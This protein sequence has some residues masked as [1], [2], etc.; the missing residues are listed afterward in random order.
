[1]L[2]SKSRVVAVLVGGGVYERVSSTSKTA[3][4]RSSWGALESKGSVLRNYGR[5]ESACA[6][7]AS[8]PRTESVAGG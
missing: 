6:R 5:R 4:G 3:G 2:V 8:M 1:V 7:D